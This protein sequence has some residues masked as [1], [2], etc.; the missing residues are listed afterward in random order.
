MLHRNGCTTL[1][2]T[3]GSKAVPLNPSR[4]L[5]NHVRTN[6]GAVYNRHSHNVP[7]AGVSSCTN[8]LDQLVCAV[9]WPKRNALAEAPRSMQFRIGITQRPYG[10]SSRTSQQATYH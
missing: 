6:H 5:R 2:A 4:H 8:L 7:K 1:T 3:V 9:Q 10:L